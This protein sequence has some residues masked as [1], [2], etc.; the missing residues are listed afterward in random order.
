MNS[1]PKITDTIAEALNDWLT[2]STINSKSVKHISKFYKSLNIKHDN[3]IY[4]YR[5]MSISVDGFKK[6]LKSGKL[7][8]KKRLAESWSCKDQIAYEFMIST[9]FKKSD[10]LKC[11]I[12][13][14]RRISDRDV[15]ADVGG[16][17]DAYMQHYLNSNKDVLGGFGYDLMGYMYTLDE[18]ELM[19]RT[20]CDSCD[21]DE[22]DMIT[23]IYSSWMDEILLDFLSELVSND[24]SMDS[25][26]DDIKYSLVKENRRVQLYKKN[27]TWAAY[28]HPIKKNKKYV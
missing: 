4:Y 24:E 19:T 16:I 8:L 23:F 1:L 22:L 9:S 3:S 25:F 26:V 2:G 14:K 6:L 17:L 21:V 20:I 7:N 13:L 27:Y 28:S 5:G 11:G 15:L 10:D 12:R 18:C